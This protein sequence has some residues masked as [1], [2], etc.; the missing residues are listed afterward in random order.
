MMDNITNSQ[1]IFEVSEIWKEA[2]YNFVYWDKL[3]LNWDEE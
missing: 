3:N 2:A 1:K